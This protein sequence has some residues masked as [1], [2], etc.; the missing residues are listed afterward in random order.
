MNKY[1]NVS[2]VDQSLVGYGIVKA[3]ATINVPFKIENPNFTVI[4]EEDNKEVV[5]TAAPQPN[6]ITDAA[7]QTDVQKTDKEA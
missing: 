4:S 7:P 1:E 2:G 3:G 6:A 5:A